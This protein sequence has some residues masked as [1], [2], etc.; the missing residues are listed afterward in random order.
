MRLGA[1]P[2]SLAAGAC[3][4]NGVTRQSN[5]ANTPAVRV[6]G[7]TYTGN[8]VTL[9]TTLGGT[10]GAQASADPDRSS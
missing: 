8:S 5:V 4:D 10:A 2:V 6:T 3:E 1:R 7:G 9:Q